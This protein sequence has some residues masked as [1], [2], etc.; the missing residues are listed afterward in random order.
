MNTEVGYAQALGDL[1]SNPIPSLW[2]IEEELRKAPAAIKN[3]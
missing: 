3:T 2:D 1:L